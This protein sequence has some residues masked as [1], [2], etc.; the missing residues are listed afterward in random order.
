MGPERQD[1]RGN[2]L[3]IDVEQCTGRQRNVQK[4]P[5]DGGCP[6]TGA[7]RQHAPVACHA[8]HV[9]L[10]GALLVRDLDVPARQQ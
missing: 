9:K 1:F 10:E 6:D 8:L 3:Q 2:V 5:F 4:L 7:R